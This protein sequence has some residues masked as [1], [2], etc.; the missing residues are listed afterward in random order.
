MREKVVLVV[1]GTDP[2]AGAG[3]YADLKTLGAIFSFGKNAHFFA[4]QKNC[5]LGVY[6]TAVV[7]AV[8]AQNTRGVQ[9]VLYLPASLVR[10]QLKSIFSDVRIDAV[11]I[12][13]LGTRGNVN[14]VVRALKRS[15]VRHVI[16]DPVFSAQ[17]DGKKL[18][19]K[20]ALSA[21]RKKLL[22]LAE[23]VTPNAREAETLASMKIKNLEDA[24]RAAR[25][26]KKMGAGNVIVKGVREKGEVV[27]VA[28]VGGE[29]HLFRKKIVSGGTHGGGCVFASAL[30]ANLAMGK[31][32]GEAVRGAE[33][34]IDDAIA[35]RKRIGK[36]VKV[37][38]PLAREMV[39]E[40]ER[41]R[42][43]KNLRRALSLVEGCGN[44]AKLIPE[45]GTNIGYA[46]R[47]A[48]SENDVAGVVGRIRNARG[49]PKSLGI[50]DFGASSHVARMILEM[51]RFDK[52]RRAAVNIAFSPEILRACKRSGLRVAVADRE[53]EPGE[54]SETEGRSLSW[55]TREAVKNA[56]KLRKLRTAPDC[57]HYTASLGKEP[58]I[59]LFGSDA[60]DV[61]R[62][63]IRVANFLYGARNR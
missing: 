35:G 19:E 39:Y 7:T 59:V 46:L 17:P 9:R 58:S 12:G 57:I 11:K 54:I 61:A 51:M 34:F 1:G 40:G 53:K 41:G 38:N 28:L 48:K 23:I 63:A 49:M 26:I 52:G 43:I 55:A 30:A 8:L 20:S 4:S 27:D 10:A 22:P 2:D 21:M 47:G 44:F 3:V 36:G 24:R 18:I 60:L 16:L 32:T 15:G 5:A 13:M 50:V 45:I 6:G 37:V 25:A 56:H 29:F 14:E 31:N 33:E 62:K 42:V